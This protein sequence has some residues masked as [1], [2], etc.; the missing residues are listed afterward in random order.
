MTNQ[1]AKIEDAIFFLIS[2]LFAF[3]GDGLEIGIQSMRLPRPDRSGLA[4]TQEVIT[5]RCKHIK[6]RPSI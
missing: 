4:M 2:L 6:C 5:Q 3:Q 1:N